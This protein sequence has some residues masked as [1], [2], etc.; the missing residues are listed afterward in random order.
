MKEIPKTIG[1]YRVI[2]QAGEGGMGLV[3][4]GVDEK[5]ARKVAIKFPKD[6]PGKTG[7]LL[8]KRFERESRS[9]SAIRHPNLITL[10]EVGEHEGRPYA[11]M[12][13]IDGKTL[14]DKVRSGGPLPDVEAARLVAKVAIATHYL[15]LNG[16]LHRD[17]KPENI[18]LR[19]DEPVLA[20]LG[21]VKEV[22][23]ESAELTVSGSALGTPDYAAPEL[24]SGDHEQTG[25][26]SDVFGLG[27]TPYFLLTG[28]PPRGPSRSI[29]QFLAQQIAPPTHHRPD[30]DAS[31]SDLCRRA[32]ARDPQRRF[33]SAQLLADSLIRWTLIKEQG[34]AI[35]GRGFASL[36]E[37]EG[38]HEGYEERLAQEPE[39]APAWLLP[40]AVSLCL[41]GIL[42]L[43]GSVAVVA[44]H[45][46]QTARPTPSVAPSP[47]RPKGP[48]VWELQ[49]QLDVA[50]QEIALL[51]SARRRSPPPEPKPRRPVRQVPAQSG[52]LKV[53]RRLKALRDQLASL[54]VTVFRLEAA[55]GGLTKDLARAPDWFR[56]LPES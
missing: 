41:V 17:I 26:S 36:W 38:I 51:L 30:L 40:V 6:A 54:R 9:L 33:R 56:R 22:D 45:E 46:P 7:E 2:G 20:D 31:L 1:R 44:G 13:W 34:K 21:L 10:Y 3:L 47:S 53:N 37:D 16:Y 25:P 18:L 52:S 39:Q 19:N 28:H 5:L 12:E 15:H 50:N 35:Y 11:V 32:L 23:A 8:R 48:T 14:G 43:L 4:E 29:V 27:A 55:F 24:I 42:S 49:Q